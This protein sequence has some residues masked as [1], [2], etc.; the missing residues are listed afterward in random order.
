MNW[1]MLVLWGLTALCAFVLVGLFVL[2]TF[3]WVVALVAWFAMAALVGLLVR[4]LLQ[5]TRLSR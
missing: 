1:T 2:P 5:A 3:G 4:G